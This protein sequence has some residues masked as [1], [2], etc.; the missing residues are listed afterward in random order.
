LLA[1]RWLEVEEKLRREELHPLFALD[2]ISSH[3]TR[4]VRKMAMICITIYPAG[5]ARNS[6]T[7]LRG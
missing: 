6:F 7:E 1:L 3:M 2:R 5:V 4:P